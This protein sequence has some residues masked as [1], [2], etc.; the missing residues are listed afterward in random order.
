MQLNGMAA[1]VSWDS[2][3]SQYRDLYQKLLGIS[4]LTGAIGRH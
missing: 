4:G 1:D 3:A 2:R